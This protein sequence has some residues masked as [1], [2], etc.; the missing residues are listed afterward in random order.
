M[1]IHYHLTEEDFVNFNLYHS[2]HSKAATRPLMVQRIVSPILFIAVAFLFSTIGGIPLP[3]SLTTFG[4][5]SILWVLFY[6]K[7][8][9]HLIKRNAK[10]MIREGRND[11]LLGDH[12]MSLTEGWSFRFHW[13][14]GNKAIL[15]GNQRVQRGCPLFLSI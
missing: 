13:Q 1:K 14:R 3:F 9:Y 7:Y 2:R 12:T 5:L 4:I 8:F 6:P 15:V 11:G 10:K